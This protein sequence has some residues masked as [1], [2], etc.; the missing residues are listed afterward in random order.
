MIYKHCFYV[1][2]QTNIIRDNKKNAHVRKRTI[3]R[4]EEKLPS[5]DEISENDKERSDKEITPKKDK[6][7]D[8]ADDKPG[9]SLVK[10]LLMTFGFD[11][12]IGLVWML[13]NT[14][15]HFFNP[16]LLK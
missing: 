9:V 11:F 6:T 14:C 2:S 8:D 13:G 3:S 5:I 7:Q 4:N 12:L 16:V 10:V 15:L 1:L